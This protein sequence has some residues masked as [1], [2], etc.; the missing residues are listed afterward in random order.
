MPR[1]RVTPEVMRQ[2]PI[3]QLQ[4]LIRRSERTITTFETRVRNE[5][6]YL[7]D[8]RKTKKSKES[9]EDQSS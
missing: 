1:E 3:D 5:R 2:L 9:S 6:R 8:L 7:E 4:K